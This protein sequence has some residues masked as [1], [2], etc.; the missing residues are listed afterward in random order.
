MAEAPDPHPASPSEPENAQPANVTGELQLDTSISSVEPRPTSSA[1]SHSTSSVQT[2]KPPEETGLRADTPWFHT[3]PGITR[4]VISKTEEE[5]LSSLSALMRNRVENE[6]L[7][8]QM[9]A[10]MQAVE[11]AK[12]ELLGIKNQIR[13]AGDE[14]AARRNEHTSLR[15]EIAQTQQTLQA[16][17][18]KHIEHQE[19]WFKT[20]HELEESRRN[21]QSAASE[22]GDTQETTR[23]MKSQVAELKKEIT[24]LLGE[25]ESTLAQLQPIRE[26]LDQRLSAREAVI[27]Q[28]SVLHQ[29]V[30]SLSQEK[31]T[32][33]KATPEQVSERVHLQKE[34]EQAREEIAQLRKESERLRSDHQRLAAAKQDAGAELSDVQGR[35]T[36]L[37]FTHA[38]LSEQINQAHQ[39]HTVLQESLKQ[40]GESHNDLLQK[41][42]D[43]K[44]TLALTERQH[45]EIS[46]RLVEAQR[47]TTVKEPETPVPQPLRLG[48]T[49]VEPVAKEEPKA[50]PAPHAEP[51][52]AELPLVKSHPI[53]PVAA[54]WDS[55]VLESEFFTEETLDAS[56][57]AELV[58]NLP[59]IEHSLIVRQFGAVL[60]D[61][62]PVR[63]HSL[64]QVP[65]RDYALL[66]DRLPNK[67][68]DYQNLATRISTYQIGDE[69]LTLSGAKDVFL[70]VTHEAPTLRPGLPEKI[71][72][73]AEELGKM[74]P[75]QADRAV[76]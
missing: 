51:V 62:L 19:A 31:D 39:N 71:A 40:A 44:Q 7:Q 49:S 26:E 70:A 14:L 58:T 9:S 29:H 12:K 41:I 53:P 48:A 35:L 60:A 69:F 75:G 61:R 64:F 13:S 50:E 30:E 4:A 10:S 15:D 55:Y 1:G 16:E 2:P 38:E 23:L 46:K 18:G 65:R 59:G 11:D 42:D 63:L 32:L 3:E 8:R 67:V 21:V 5:L 73:V 52:E 47:Q 57:V 76:T 74:Y 56:R 43:A 27:E 22:L 33:S 17:R 6:K 28:V 24:R 72:I 66:Y 45:E 25:R 54:S 37:R 36:S 68:R 34:L 20:R